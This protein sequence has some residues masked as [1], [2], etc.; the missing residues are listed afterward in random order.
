MKVKVEYRKKTSKTAKKSK[1]I[2]M[3]C[4]TPT[5][6]TYSPVCPKLELPPYYLRLK[7]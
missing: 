7:I 5:A 1:E 3:Q 2:I 4:N 6:V